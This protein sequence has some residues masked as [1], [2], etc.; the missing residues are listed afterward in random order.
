ML[1]G[2]SRHPDERRQFLIHMEGSILKINPHGNPILK[3]LRES[4]TSHNIIY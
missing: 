4:T 1:D 3:Y 2:R